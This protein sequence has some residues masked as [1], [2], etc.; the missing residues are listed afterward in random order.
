MNQIFFSHG[1]SY[2]SMTVPR[3]IFKE[4]PLKSQVFKDQLKTQ[5]EYFEPFIDSE[6]ILELTLNLIVR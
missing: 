1:H 2:F 5:F 4:I 6:V 3:F